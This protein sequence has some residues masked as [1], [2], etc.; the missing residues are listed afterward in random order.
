VTDPQWNQEVAD[1]A[2]R[3]L[4]WC[5][6]KF[7]YVRGS[8]QPLHFMEL[9]NFIIDDA[10]DYSHLFYLRGLRFRSLAGGPIDDE[11]KRWMDGTAVK[12]IAE[13]VARLVLASPGVGHSLVE[14]FPGVGLTGEYVKLLLHQGQAT[15]PGAKS[16]ASYEGRGPAELKNQFLVLQAEEN[17][18]IGYFSDLKPTANSADA[19]TVVNLNHSIKYGAAPD[20]PIEQFL[21]SNE[22]PVVLAL[23]A[24]SGDAGATCTTV[25]GR[26]IA[27]PSVAETLAKLKKLGSSWKFRFI[28]KFD[29][30][31]FLPSPGPRTGL[32]L[33]YDA[34]RDCPIEGFAG[35][36]GR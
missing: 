16:I 4:R 7:V 30:G 6:G 15:Q 21:A 17:V 23:R 10:I 24:V 14:Y 9:K 33:A 35:V 25:K 36:D 12:P 28:E 8:D 11:L 29:A 20:L 18:D 26:R 1:S 27:L 2:T 31:F 5:V 3:E 22:G 19:I 32:L 34:R 13:V